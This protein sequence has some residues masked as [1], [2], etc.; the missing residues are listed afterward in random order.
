MP[1]RIYQ[2]PKISPDGT[3]VALNATA[4]NN[5]D[6]WIWDLVRET[7]TRLTFDEGQDIVPIWSPDSKRIA[8]HSMRE[9]AVLKGA[10]GG[11]VFWKSADGTGEDKLLCLGSEGRL[12][13]YCWSRDGNALLITQF[14]DDGMENQDIAMLS[15]NDDNALKPLLTESYME[16]QPQL[17]PDGGWLAYC[18]GESGQNEVYVRPFPEVNKGRWQVSTNGGN[19]PLWS[20]DGS[21]VFYLIGNTEGAMAVD[22]ETEPTFK[23]GKPRLLFSGSYVGAAP[24][25][26]VPW[27]IHPDGKRFFMMK[28]IGAASGA[29]EI[30]ETEAATTQPKITIVLN[31]DEELKQRVPV[32]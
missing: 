23:P 2:F 20:P 4:N 31:W 14:I 28:P 11:G 16:M 13:P 22:V 8:F 17:S 19:S 32:P 18:S 15:M 21:E 30:D 5:A 29:T 3:R 9:S 12:I 25:D 6:I 10:M 7:L 1:P 27:D 24:A 26:G